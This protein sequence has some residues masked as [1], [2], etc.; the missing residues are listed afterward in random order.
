V[1]IKEDGEWAGL[2]KAPNRIKTSYMALASKPMPES[3]D[4]APIAEV[5]LTSFGEPA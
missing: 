3:P 2:F 1:S 4:S 5:P